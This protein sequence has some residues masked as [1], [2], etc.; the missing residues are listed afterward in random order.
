ML[1]GVSTRPPT[2]CASWLNTGFMLAQF[3]ASSKTPNACKRIFVWQPPNDLSHLVILNIHIRCLLLLPPQRRLW[4]QH[5]GLCRLVFT[6]RIPQL[7][8]I[9]TSRHSPILNLTIG[10][11]PLFDSMLVRWK[12]TILSQVACK[13]ILSSRLGIILTG[14]NCSHSVM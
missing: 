2:R 9:P 12:E 8:S 7:Y 10:S 13:W 14:D 11:P 5:P 4:R 6:L 3:C 1:C